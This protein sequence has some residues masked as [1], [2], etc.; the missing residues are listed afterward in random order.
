MNNL[1]YWKLC[2][3]LTV[4]QASLLVIGEDPADGSEEYVLGWEAHNRPEGFNAVYAALKGAIRNNNLRARIVH[5]SEIVTYS[6]AGDEKVDRVENIEPDWNLTTVL[7]EDLKAWL[8]H[9][10]IKPSFFF[11]ESVDDRDYLDINHPFYSPKLA[12]TIKA[13]ESIRDN[14]SLLKNKTPKQALEKKLREMASLYGF[15]DEHGMP[16][17]Q[18]IEDMAKV[19][20]WSTKGG[21]AKTYVPPARPN[22][23]PDQLAEND[24]D[25]NESSVPF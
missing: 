24:E 17:R 19:A 16:Q 10:N 2:D 8:A 14:T 9:R 25:F 4:I 5:N 3:H 12:A 22:P 13:W 11:S 6:L 23:S 7:V 20:N 15:T 21:V 18:A 1:D